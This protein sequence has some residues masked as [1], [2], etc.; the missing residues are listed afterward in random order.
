MNEQKK[1]T[2]FEIAESFFEST[3]F[4]KYIIDLGDIILNFFNSNKESINFF[5]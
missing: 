3:L 1:T 2:N 5:N 4:Y